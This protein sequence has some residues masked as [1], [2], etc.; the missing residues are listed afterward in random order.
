M[1]PAEEASYAL[2][3]DLDP[4][5]LKPDVRAE[6]DRLKN[7]R[8]T[9]HAAQVLA[10]PSRTQVKVPA[11]TAPAILGLVFLLAWLIIPRFPAGSVGG[12]SF[13]V[14]QAHLLCD[15]GLGTF[16]QVFDAALRNRCSLVDGAY[17]FA[18]LFGW[19]GLICLAGS[20]VSFIKGAQTRSN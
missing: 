2:D 11:V 14:G 18:G 20:V 7:T 16:G 8:H 9:R 12:T 5:G 3:Y 19:L 13:S 4:A 6:Y 15:S 17:E 1:T 10:A